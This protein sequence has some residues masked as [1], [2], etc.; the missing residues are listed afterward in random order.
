MTVIAAPLSIVVLNS[1]GFSKHFFEFMQRNFPAWQLYWLTSKELISLS[2]VVDTV[3][4][5]ADQKFDVFRSELAAPW[6]AKAVN[7]QDALVQWAPKSQ[8]QSCFLNTVNAATSAKQRV[9]VV[10]NENKGYRKAHYEVLSILEQLDWEP[11]LLCRR[12]LNDPAE[13]RFAH[14]LVENNFELATIIHQLSCDLLIA[15]NDIPPE[16]MQ[17]FTMPRLYIPHGVVGLLERFIDMNADQQHMFTLIDNSLMRSFTHVFVPTASVLAAF[18][19]LYQRK[20]HKPSTWLIPGGYLNLDLAI[21][22]VNLESERNTILYCPSAIPQNDPYSQRIP[23]SFPHDSFTILHTL[24]AHFPEHKIMFRHHPS[25]VE[26][27]R[28]KAAIDAINEQLQSEPRYI[29]D[30]NPTHQEAFAKAQLVISDASTSAYTFSLSHCLPTVSFLPEFIEKPLVIHDEVF[31]SSRQHLGAVVT[32]DINSLMQTVASLLNATDNVSGAIERFR[33]QEY[34]NV[35]K[36][37][38]SLEQTLMLI[39]EGEP[40]ADWVSLA[41]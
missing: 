41:D 24:L 25:A 33:M 35:G 18:I 40:S 14:C 4:I 5:V 38:K 15:D 2:I 29:Y 23:V 17:R 8:L 36:V 7:Y 27:P 30:V 11:I 13:Q 28:F 32:G 3:V 19:A 39:V 21:Q 22:A 26:V 20:D 31:S 6:Q 34:F 10:L 1:G 9:A 12:L 37:A 16:T